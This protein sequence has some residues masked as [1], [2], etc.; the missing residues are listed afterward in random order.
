MAL[1]S[2]E[3]TRIIYQGIYTVNVPSIYWIPKGGNQ[4]F[5]IT[6]NKQW[7]EKPDFTKSENRKV[8][9]QAIYEVSP[10][11]EA[12]AAGVWTGSIVS[13]PVSVVIDIT[14]YDE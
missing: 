7:K 11:P 13:E 14:S 9:L 12:K 5:P 8:K 4:V 10:S 2:G 6:L 3:S 1:P